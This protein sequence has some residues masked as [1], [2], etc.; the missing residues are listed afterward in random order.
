M[1]IYVFQRP[2]GTQWADYSDLGSRPGYKR[3]REIELVTRADME[4]VI[5]SE[6]GRIRALAERLL[7]E[8]L[9]RSQTPPVTRQQ[10]AVAV[11]QVE[12]WN[13]PRRLK[14]LVTGK[15]GNG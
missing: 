1:L 4:R 8:H 7:D 14:W 13:M 12:K 15:S 9:G 5:K 2:D 6:S 10:H 11:A 3:I